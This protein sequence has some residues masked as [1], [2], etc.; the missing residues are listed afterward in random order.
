MGED[1]RK[2]SYVTF[3]SSYL[4]YAGMMLHIG[5]NSSNVLIAHSAP[6]CNMR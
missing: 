4:Q 2:H 3:P 6:L 1:D 5:V